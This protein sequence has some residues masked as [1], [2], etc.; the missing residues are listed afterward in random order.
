MIFL[1]MKGCN[2][3]VTNI[4]YI[5]QAFS[6]LCRSLY[7]TTRQMKKIG[8]FLLFLAFFTGAKAH[9]QTDTSKVRLWLKKNERFKPEFR[10]MLQLWGI[11]ATGMEVYNKGAMRY[12]PVDDRLNLF[13]RRA[14]FVVSGEP[15]KRL[16]YTTMFLYDQ[17]GRDVLTSGIGGSNKADPAVGI[18]DAFLQWQVTT[19]EVL[20]LTGGWFRPQ[21]QRESITS[22]WATNSFEKSM[23]QNYVRNHLTGSN[24][25]RTMG[26]NA[27]GLVQW[28]MA[29]IKK[30]TLNY[31]L[32]IFNPVTAALSGTSAG[33]KFSPLFAGRISLSFGD[34][35]MTRY[36]LSYDINYFNKRK[37]ASLD[38]NYSTQGET[39]LFKSSRA[40]GP[41]LLFNWGPLN[42]DSEWIWLERK[43]DRTLADGSVRNFKAVSSTGHVRVGT[44]IPAGRFILEPVIMAMQF[45]GAM[46]AAGQDDATAV[47]ESSGE[48]TTFDAGLN[49][50]LDG[51]NLKI[52]LHYTWHKGDP[53]DAGEGSQ[54]NMFF[55]Q[56]SVG[57]IRRGDWLG[58]GINAVF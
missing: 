35:E 34:P 13:M 14:R 29:L 27:G 23:S 48:E 40:Y 33:Y 45:Y 49:W 12:D 53:G 2:T 46:D 38:F 5:L 26:L 6:N 30:A 52:M 21:M 3:F 7:R 16:K 58:L 28:D 25:G 54:V 22:G 18:L 50:Y 15:Y 9:S 56:N 51:K 44:N 11:Y 47:K 17:A 8:Q 36:G 37:G 57:A 20:N 10:T 4:T 32:G 1:I 39:D 55:S 43:G 19:N 42:L 41:G 24:A 31:N